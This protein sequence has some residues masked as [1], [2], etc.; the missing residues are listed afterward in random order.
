MK[1]STDILND[2]IVED[3]Y[4][5]GWS[6]QPTYFDADLIRQL[7]TEAQQ[8]YQNQQMIQAGI[9]RGAALHHNPTVRQD[10]IHWLNGDSPVQRHYQHS[11]EKLRLAINRQ[12]MLGLFELEAHYAVYEAGAFY[13]KH[14]DSFK[15]AANRMVSAVTYLNNDWPAT[16]GGELLIYDENQQNV[17]RRV[18]PLAGTLAVF[19]SEQIPHEVAVTHQQRLSIAGWFRLN[20]A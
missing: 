11:M 19:L 15:G 17:I 5:Q 2:T 20:Q 1:P 18:A 13:K 8:L 14:I 9:G 3:L 12:L 6:V 16:A 7:S 4:Q 10:F